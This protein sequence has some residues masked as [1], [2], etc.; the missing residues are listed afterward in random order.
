MK[1]G[2]IIEREQAWHART[3]Q[4]GIGNYIPP[5]WAITVIWPTDFKGSY[6]QRTFRF[7]GLN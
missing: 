3:Q 1:I 5:C 4:G 6:K 2:L 7:G